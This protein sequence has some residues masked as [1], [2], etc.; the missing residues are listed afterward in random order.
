M[1]LIFDT[2]DMIDVMVNGKGRISMNVESSSNW[3]ILGTQLCMT[4]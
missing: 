2:H 3:E 4:S 1:R